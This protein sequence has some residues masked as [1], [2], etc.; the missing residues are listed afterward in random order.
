MKRCVQLIWFYVTL[1][2]FI[3]DYD[4]D[5]DDEGTCNL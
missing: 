4:G 5:D 3:Y 1:N 2:A